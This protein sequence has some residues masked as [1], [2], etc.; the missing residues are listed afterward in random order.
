MPNFGN[1]WQLYVENPT[2]KLCQKFRKLILG[3]WFVSPQDTVTTWAYWATCK[4]M[5]NKEIILPGLYYW[6]TKIQVTI[7][8]YGSYKYKFD[9]I[10]T[11]L[12]LKPTPTLKIEE[13]ACT[14]DS[15]D[16]HILLI[17]LIYTFHTIVAIR[18]HFFNITILVRRLT[19]YLNILLSVL[20]IL[21]F[22]S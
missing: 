2:R 18:D 14:C 16:T 9:L 21:F 12:T 7:M 13:D 4:L 20:P 10:L 17:Q 15:D 6:C 8:L 5:E 11:I 22:R 19:C 3:H 1:Y